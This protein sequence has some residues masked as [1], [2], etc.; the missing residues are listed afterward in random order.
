M[1]LGIEVIPFHETFTAEVRGVDWTS[2]ITPEV[3]D[4]IQD[5]IDKV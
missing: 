4:F 2:P 3:K 1:V 5:A